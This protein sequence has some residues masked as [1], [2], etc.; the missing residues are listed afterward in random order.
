MQRAPLIACA[1][2]KA[3]LSTP[4][5]HISLAE[6]RELAAA[7]YQDDHEDL[8]LACVK[9]DVERVRCLLDKSTEKI[10]TRFSWSRFDGGAPL[11]IAVECNRTGTSALARRA[12]IVRLLLERG[13][14][15]NMGNRRG[16]TP[17]Q[18][19][20]ACSSLEEFE[21]VPL[22]LEYGADPNYCSSDIYTDRGEPPLQKACKFNNKIPAVAEVLLDRGADITKG[23]A[24]TPLSVAIRGENLAVARVLLARGAPVDD[25]PGHYSECGTPLY[26]ACENLRV[27]ATRLLLAHGAAWDRPYLLKEK[28][29]FRPQPLPSPL[30]CVRR[31][32]SRQ[33]T[34]YMNGRTVNFLE[35]KSKIN[36]LFDDFLA[37]Y[38]RLR[39][40]PRLFGRRE[41][42]ASGPQRMVLGDAYLPTKIGAFVVGDGIL[43][44]KKN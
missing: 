7:M 31:A 42:H 24:W 32:T 40:A 10:N 2:E 39:V 14:D 44:K 16:H 18:L 13:A 30:T 33:E 12:A 20:C 41:N 23:I 43:V 38:W 29:G 1:K 15:V 17:L 35:Q 36:R 28:G 3:L 26:L 21:V 22:L 19:A 8:W 11:H 34:M 27:N 25:P 6:P 5:L 37:H 4:A 9:G